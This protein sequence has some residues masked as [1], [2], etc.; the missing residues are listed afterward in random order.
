MHSR[1]T[2]PVESAK[3]T[4]RAGITFGVGR[5]HDLFFSLCLCLPPSHVCSLASS[6]ASFTSPGRRVPWPAFLMHQADPAA[7]ARRVAPSTSS[8]RL[9]QEATHWA[10]VHPCCRAG[11]ATG[12]PYLSNTSQGRRLHPIGSKMRPCLDWLSRLWS[13]TTS[14]A[15]WRRKL[16]APDSP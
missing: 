13:S 7:P 8:C 9:W 12:V 4:S 15:L 1:A 11:P 16:C 5:R 14:N 3:S 2:D 6:L 10:D